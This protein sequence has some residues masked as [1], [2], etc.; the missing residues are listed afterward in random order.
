[1]QVEE[2]VDRTRGEIEVTEAEQKMLSNQIALATVQLNISEE[3]KAPLEGNAA[4]VRIRL[5][6]AAVEGYRNVVEGIISV[7]AFLLSNGP[8]L[9]IALAIASVPMRWLWRRWQDGRLPSIG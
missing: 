8:A 3:F 5:R 7:V 2:A 1:L 9:L 4:P 6:N